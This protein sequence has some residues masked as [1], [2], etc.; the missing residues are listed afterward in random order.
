MAGSPHAQVASL[1]GT[2]ILLAGAPSTSISC[3]LASLQ[4]KDAW[5][6]RPGRVCCICLQLHR[7]DQLW[8]CGP[9][10]KKPPP[11]IKNGLLL[12][13]H[14]TSGFI[15][16]LNRGSHPHPKHLKQQRGSAFSVSQTDIWRCC[17]QGNLVPEPTTQLG[18]D[19]HASSVG[20]ALYP[21]I[22]F[23]L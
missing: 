20:H 3:M 12:M 19:L 17:E 11:Y 18:W 2:Q 8:L 10:K 9:D 7:Q 1:Y 15:L 6:V 13:F 16:L 4:D 5:E 22:H 14:M 23:F 21:S